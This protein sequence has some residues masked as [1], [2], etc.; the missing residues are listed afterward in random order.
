ML[1][2]TGLATAVA[3]LLFAVAAFGFLSPP[4]PTMYEKVKHLDEVQ[5]FFEKYP[6]A[7][8]TG[9]FQD[10]F[11][12]CVEICPEYRW[13]LFSHWSAE[14]EGKAQLTVYVPQTSSDLPFRFEV[15]CNKA[16]D[17]DSPAKIAG[18]RIQNITAFLNSDKCPPSD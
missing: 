13:V 10:P 11:F 18:T 14:P 5:N 3:S 6:D 8:P 17:I 9:R 1:V 7:E 2:V 4:E 12:D 16:D 15:W